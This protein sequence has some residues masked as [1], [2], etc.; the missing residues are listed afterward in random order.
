MEAHYSFFLCLFVFIFFGSL[1]YFSFC[2]LQSILTNI[3]KPPLCYPFISLDLTFPS[4]R[5]FLSER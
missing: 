1:H 4:A 2:L 5:C 3:T